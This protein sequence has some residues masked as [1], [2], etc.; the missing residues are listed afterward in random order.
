MVSYVQAYENDFVIMLTDYTVKEQ[1]K[2]KA[3]K[4][5]RLLDVQHRIDELDTLFQ[6]IYEDNVCGKLSDSRFQKLSKGYEEEQEQLQEEVKNL[7][8]EMKSAEQQIINVKSFLAIVQ[9][10]TR[11]TELTPEIYMNL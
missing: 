11:I 4:K 8:I 3:K 1:G 2:E 6:H 9:S 5:Y 10:Y 7:E